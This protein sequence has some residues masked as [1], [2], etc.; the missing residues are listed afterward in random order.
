MSRSDTIHYPA[1]LCGGQRPGKESGLWSE[2]GCGLQAAQAHLRHR[3]WKVWSEAD[4]ELQEEKEGSH[5]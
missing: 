1:Q 2:A 3:N 5:C 4:G